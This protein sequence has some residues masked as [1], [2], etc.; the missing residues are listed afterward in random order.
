MEFP[1]NL[2][3]QIDP[4]VVFVCFFFFTTSQWKNELKF[5]R[6]KLKVQEWPFIYISLFP[7]LFTALYVMPFATTQCT[8]YTW[9]LC[10]YLYGFVCVSV[11]VSTYNTSH[12]DTFYKL[13]IFPF[14]DLERILGQRPGA[15]SDFL[16][17]RLWWVNWVWLSKSFM[18]ASRLVLTGKC[19]VV[20][21]D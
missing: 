21:F 2:S 7:S 11:K 4:Q 16:F 20:P 10:L 18:A 3:M 13:D 17:F 1:V 9:N 19:G 6:D 15:C 5:I 14:S 12:I 8:E